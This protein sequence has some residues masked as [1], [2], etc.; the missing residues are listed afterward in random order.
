[1]P[2]DKEGSYE[3]TGS[4]PWVALK[5]GKNRKNA[6]SYENL[7]RTSDLA[8]NFGKINAEENGH[9]ILEMECWKAW[10]KE[11]TRKT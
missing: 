6:T 10:R 5:L 2:P 7:H 3:H 9:Q 8:E 1:L 4:T 11:T